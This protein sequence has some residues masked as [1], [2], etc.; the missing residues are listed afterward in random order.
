MSIIYELYKAR[1]KKVCPP[2]YTRVQTCPLILRSTSEDIITANVFG[3]LK[4]LNPHIWLQGFLSEALHC[5]F[6]SA[7]FNNLKFEF[8]KKLSPPGNLS[9]KEGISEV[10]MV[11]SFDN[12]IVLLEANTLP[13]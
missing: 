13:L 1:G 4:N 12:S 11:I 7:C 2:N 5:D 10:D 6:T 3:I 8:W 9:H